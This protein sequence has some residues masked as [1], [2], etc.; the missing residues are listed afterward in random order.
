MQKLKVITLG[1]IL[2][3]SLITIILA[4]FINFFLLPKS[5]VIENKVITIQNNSYANTITSQLFKENI[6]KSKLA[7][8]IYLKLFNKE[9]T[10]R[11]GSFLLSPSMSLAEIAH[12]LATNSGDYYL[13]KVTIPEG[14]SIQQIAEIFDKKEIINKEEFERYVKYAAKK[15]FITKYSFLKN[16]PYETIE[17]YLYPETYFFRKNENKK[18]ITNKMLSEFNKNIISI[19]KQETEKTNYSLHQLST[20][21]SMIEKEARSKDDMGKISSVF[22][23]RLKK[24][25]PLAS[26]PTVVYAHGKSYKK[27]VYYKDLE[28]KSPYNTYKVKGLPPTPIASFG[29]AAFLAALNPDKTPYLFFVAKDDGTHHFSKTYREHLAVQK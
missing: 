21:A 26:D 19:F 17:G 22:Y 9:Q 13:I 18:I 5:N 8:K 7:F 1:I 25:M 15:E 12:I 20:L 16:Y 3:I 28:I 11:S 29:E 10:L 24:R 4:L 2:S 14:Y 6:I 23:N 27:R